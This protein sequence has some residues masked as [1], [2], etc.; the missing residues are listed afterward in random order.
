[1]VLILDYRFFSPRGCCEIASY[2]PN[3]HTLDWILPDNERRD[4]SRRMRTRQEFASGVTLLPQSVRRFTLNYIDRSPWDHSWT[5]PR[6]YYGDTST[7][8]PLSVAFRNLAQ[9]L[10]TL[11][12][13]RSSIVIGSDIFWP[14][15]IPTLALSSTPDDGLPSFPHLERLDIIASI[16]SASG[17]WLFNADPAKRDPDGY[18][19]ES[20]GDPFRDDWSPQPGD[21]FHRFRLIPV[22]ELVDPYFVAAARAVARMPRLRR[23][24]LHFE[25]PLPC[26]VRY[27][28]LEDESKATLVFMGSPPYNPSEEVRQAWR[29]AGG[30][31]TL[32]WTSTYGT[33]ARSGK[34]ISF[35]RV[36]GMAGPSCDRRKVM[37]SGC[38]TCGEASGTL[39]DTRV[40]LETY[41]RC[42]VD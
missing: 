6:L 26:T 12:F 14:A 10:V 31:A 30:F 2:L 15:I 8:D 37:L 22:A 32:C 4:V 40:K 20:D 23:F 27:T 38:S 42:P 3:V 36:G 33:Q 1:M 5:P 9:R 13:D 19:R 35:E 16:A 28:V 39:K 25:T 7:P 11:S 29:A 18:D 34:V 41:A 17:G 24:E 21:K